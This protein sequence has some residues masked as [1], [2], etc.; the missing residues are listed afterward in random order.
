MRTLLLMLV[1]A[2]AACVIPFQAIINGRLGQSVQNPL[3]ASLI[4]FTTGT[5]ALAVVLLAT[6]PGWPSLPA[7]PS[8]SW[9]LFTGGLLGA[10]FVTA[11]LVLVPRIGTANVLAASIVG[12]L[13]MSLIIDHFGLLGIPQQGLSGVRLL[14]GTLLVLGMLL[15]QRG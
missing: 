4:S 13:V 10:V 5:V 7:D 14:G 8:R 12:Q 2:L 11:V 15:I 9:S 1:A 3:L 6:T